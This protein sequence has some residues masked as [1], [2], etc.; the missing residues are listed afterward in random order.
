MSS[1]LGI[2]AD[3]ISPASAT[4][5]TVR[6]R[7]IRSALRFEPVE[8]AQIG[9]QHCR[10]D[11]RSVRLL[12]VFQHRDQR[13][14]HRKA[15]P[16]QRVN[17]ARGLL[18][19]RP[20]ARVHPPRLEIARVRTGRNLAPR[21]LARQPYFE[22][23][24]LARAE[25]HVARAEQDA[26]IGQV[27]RLQHAFRT[28]RHALMLG[29]A[30]LGT[31]DADQLDLFELVLAD[32]PAGH[33][34]V[35]LDVAI[36][37]GL[38]VEHEL[39]ERPVQPRH[40]PAQ[41]RKARARQIGARLEV[42]A[43]RR[44]DVGMLAWR[45]VE[46]ARGSPAGLFDVAGLVLAVGDVRCGQIGDGGQRALEREACFGIGGLETGQRLFQR[47]DFGHER[48][49]AHFLV[50]AGLRVLGSGDRSAARVVQRDELGGLGGSAPAGEGGV[51]G[52][53]IVPD[54]ADVVHGA[55]MPRRA[56]GGNPPASAALSRG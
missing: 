33:G 41:E 1:T 21:L 46:R 34:R 9:S 55:A 6:P 7:A 42:H 11:D 12:I 3:S 18:A 4:P 36:V 26:S 28:T 54:G 49:R 10:H 44:T 40:W 27:Q 32:E 22:V 2:H 23:E 53:G 16:V 43:Q 19:L 25:A 30:V 29:V 39:G 50:P 14:S 24:G 37:G 56:S 45:E 48:L 17:E 38:V 52:G 31:A 13:T 47:R 35:A 5:V 51:E 8:P 20:V 15:G